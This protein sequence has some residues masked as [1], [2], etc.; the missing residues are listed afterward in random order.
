MRQ[1]AEEAARHEFSIPIARVMKLAETHLP[2]PVT[3]WRERAHEDSASNFDQL[4]EQFAFNKAGD[5]VWAL[6]QTQD[7]RITEE[8]P[9][10][11]VQGD[12]EAGR[13][14]IAELANNVYFA[15]E[16]LA[17]YMPATSESVRKA[18]L[19]NAKPENLF[20]RLA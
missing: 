8:R 3:P 5:L 10:A 19:A 6:L 14:A 4:I 9:F 16:L 1:L 11:L 12:P 17:P 2:G 18:V 20:P 15:A 7:L 13:K